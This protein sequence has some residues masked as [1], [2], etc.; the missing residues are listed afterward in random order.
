[1]N[2]L[3]RIEVTASSDGEEYNCV[4]YIPVNQIDYYHENGDNTV[5]VVNREPVYVKVSVEDIDSLVR[6]G[7]TVEQ[8]SGYIVDCLQVSAP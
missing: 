1:M 4:T 5:I 2:R 6:T 3:E 7:M 8:Y